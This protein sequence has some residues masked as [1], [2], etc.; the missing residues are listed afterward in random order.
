M[1]SGTVA[2]MSV[3]RT[4]GR[5]MNPLCSAPSTKVSWKACLSCG[6]EA[7]GWRSSV[8]STFGISCR[9]QITA[10]APTARKATVMAEPSARLEW[11]TLVTE[12]AGR[13]M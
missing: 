12:P 3:R 11:N 2:A 13:P 10:P 4:I 5:L 1:A 6:D 8:T 7:R 9:T